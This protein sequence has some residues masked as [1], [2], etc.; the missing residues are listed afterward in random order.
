MDRLQEEMSPAERDLEFLEGSP[1]A[2]MLTRSPSTPVNLVS[3][4]D[5]KAGALNKDNVSKEHSFDEKAA[6]LTCHGIGTVGD[7]CASEGILDTPEDVPIVSP[8]LENNPDVTLDSST[9]CAS[10][11]HKFSQNEEHNNDLSHVATHKESMVVSDTQ[12][13]LTCS[14]GKTIDDLADF[15]GL[16][17]DTQVEEERTS[18][19]QPKIRAKIKKA[20]SK[21]RR[22][23]QK[24]GASTVDALSQNKE[25]D[26]NQAGCVEISYSQTHLGTCNRTVD[27]FANSD[28]IEEPAQEEMAAK[29]QPKLQPKPGG[30][31][32]GVTETI[33]VVAVATPEVGGFDVDVASQDTEED[34]H[35]EGLNDDLCQKHMDEEANTVSDTG[36]PQDVDAI[37]D[38]DSH[39]KM[40]NP[41]LDGSP[42]II[43]EP[44]G[45]A[46]IKFQPY[47]RRKKGKGKSVSFSPP[48]VSDLV[49]PTEINS[50]TSSFSHFCKDIATGENLNNLPQQAAEKVCVTE[51]HQPDDQEY[52]GPENQYHEGE[53]SDYV[54]EQEPTRDV[55]ETGTSMKLRSRKKIQKDPIPE[56]ADDNMDEDLIEPPSDEQDNDS[57]DE[58]TARGKQKDRRKS[59]EKNINKEPSR[60][61][62]RTSGDSTIE[63]SQKQKLQKN[64]SKASSGGQKKTS[65]DLS[66]EQPEKKLTHR[67]RQKRMKEVK[68]LLETPDHEIDRMKLSVT[69]LRLLQEARDRIKGKEI[70]SGPSSSNHSNSQFGDMDDEYNEQENWDNDRTEN[71]VVENATKL[72]YH[73]YMN[74]QTRAKWSKSDT[75]LFYQG[76]RQFGSDFAMIQHL[77]P[78]KSRNQVRQKFKAEEKRHPMQVH[79]A[80]M[81]RSRDNSY[82]KKVIK[83]LNIEDVQPD[84]SNTHEQE[85]ASNE[86]DPGNKNMSDEFI[87]EEEENGS[88]WPDKELDMHRSEVE[89]KEHVS[90]NADDDLGDVFDWY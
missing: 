20:A 50:E 24:A 30:V 18:K 84:I 63:E 10:A 58:Y 77:F 48:N 61:T 60:G 21:S 56:P 23:N 5:E 27:D 81:H 55:R 9:V 44:S 49:A 71:H 90:T 6:P 43:G 47:V 85:G 57:G 1:P 8:G 51:E 62:K 80:I 25:D 12:A 83:Q 32:P 37:V 79:D 41:H 40:V 86:E 16:C 19:F 75:D 7:A 31:L 33:D 4:H 89:E 73:S 42:P 54:I 66:V 68:T 36:L 53:P 65:K 64:K 15:E 78:D 70:P 45:E 11:V 22:A 52:N 72:N 34:T 38:L 17:D 3:S 35:R 82:F 39:T 87:N 59:R 26:K 28:T 13:P 46:T 76:L 69:H 2:T 74:R 14:S 29:F 88:N 67:I